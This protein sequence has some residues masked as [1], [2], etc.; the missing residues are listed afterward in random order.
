M[1]GSLQG[2]RADLGP[3]PQLKCSRPLRWEDGLTASEGAVG[4]RLPEL[5]ASESSTV[6][7]KG[8]R[9]TASQTQE[10]AA[11]LERGE[12]HFSR[13]LAQN[14]VAVY[15]AYCGL[16]RSPRPGRNINCSYRASRWLW[17]KPP[18]SC[19]GGTFSHLL[20]ER[21]QNKMT[22]LKQVHIKNVYIY[23]KTKTK[24]SVKWKLWTI[25]KKLQ[26]KRLKAL[27]MITE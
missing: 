19:L 13:S 8:R 24:T 22:L 25:C 4:Y 21:S 20:T 14:R 9:I 15:P 5:G 26:S 6:D 10:A 7:W 17:E 16:F 27:K 2:L 12:S 3:G 11:S 23:S 1:L 18:D